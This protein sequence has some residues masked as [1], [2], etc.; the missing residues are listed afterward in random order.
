MKAQTK[1]RI[2]QEMERHYTAVNKERNIITSVTVGATNPDELSK[3]C[4][5]HIDQ[6]ET[7]YRIT[8][9]ELIKLIE[10]LRI[11]EVLTEDELGHLELA[12]TRVLND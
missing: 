1:S 10:H 4:Q 11:G 12:V 2:F 5:R 6:N 9:D 3:W 8:H 7:I